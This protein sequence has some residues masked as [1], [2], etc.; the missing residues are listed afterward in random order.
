MTPKASQVVAVVSREA[1]PPVL[2]RSILI[3]DASA[4]QSTRASAL[5][6]TRRAARS[7]AVSQVALLSEARAT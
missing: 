5:T 7:S 3:R 2:A 6:F 4:G 1:R